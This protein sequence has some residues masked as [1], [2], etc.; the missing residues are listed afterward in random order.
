MTTLDELICRRAGCHRPA[1]EHTIPFG[2]DAGDIIRIPGVDYDAPE[3]QVGAEGLFAG[4]DIHGLYCPPELRYTVA[5]AGDCPEC[6]IHVQALGIDTEELPDVALGE[7][8]A[9]PLRCICGAEVPAIW[10]GFTL[11][12]YAPARD[13]EEDD[14]RVDRVV[15]SPSELG[16]KAATPTA[17]VDGRPIDADLLDRAVD[18]RKAARILADG[19]K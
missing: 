3:R 8:T 9:T 19:D 15:R 7:G 1:S 10:V 13:L 17:W 11:A 12:G 2:P 14:R 18:A 4:L 6:G 16:I 5:A